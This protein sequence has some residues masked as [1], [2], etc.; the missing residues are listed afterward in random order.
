MPTLA[1]TCD[2]CDSKFQ[3]KYSIDDCDDDPRFCPFCSAYILEK[4]ESEQ[5]DE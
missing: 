2:E 1:H 4:D 5:E 3:L